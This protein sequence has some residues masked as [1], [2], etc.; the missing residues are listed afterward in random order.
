M[1]VHETGTVLIPTWTSR[2]AR[3]R[4]RLQLTDFCH[5]VWGTWQVPG[6]VKGLWPS[7]SGQV[8]PGWPSCITV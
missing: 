4:V 3:V 7:R 1:M 6:N 8:R 5:F 2:T